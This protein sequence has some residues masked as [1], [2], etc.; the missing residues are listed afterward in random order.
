MSNLNAIPNPR[1]PEEALEEHTRLTSNL[2]QYSIDLGRE[3]GEENWV[4]LKALT[5]HYAILTIIHNAPLNQSAEELEAE[6]YK[7]VLNEALGRAEFF[8]LG[9]NYPELREIEN[10]ESFAAFEA[11]FLK[12]LNDAANTHIGQPGTA[13]SSLYGKY[14]QGRHFIHDLARKLQML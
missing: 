2:A 13:I 14:V 10:R 4:Q 7:R 12:E 6:H 3:L 9:S 5:D 11:M 1:D 8:E